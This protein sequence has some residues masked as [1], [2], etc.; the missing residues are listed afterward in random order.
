MRS[1]TCHVFLLQ[2]SHQTITHGTVRLWRSSVCEVCT[3]IQRIGSPPSCG[4]WA[5]T[6]FTLRWPGPE[7]DEV[8]QRGGRRM[9][10]YMDG[11]PLASPTAKQQFEE[12]ERAITLLHSRD[13]VRSP[14][15]LIEDGSVNIV[16]FY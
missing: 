14:N 2:A 11:K 1:R 5:H 13:L 3:D 8:S 4:R 6:I 7:G 12:V 16:S 10:D 15:I 9:M